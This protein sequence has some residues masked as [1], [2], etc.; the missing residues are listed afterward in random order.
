MLLHRP[1]RL[2]RSRAS[3]VKRDEARAIFLLAA[4]V[5]FCTLAAHTMI[6]P[7]SARFLKHVYNASSALGVALGVLLS[8][9][10]P[11][12]LET[13][14]V[15]ST[16]DGELDHRGRRVK[17]ERGAVYVLCEAC[18]RWRPPRAHHCRTCGRCV[19][20]LDHHCHGLRACIGQGTHG[21]FLLY[22]SLQAVATGTLARAGW[23]A[24]DEH[25]GFALGLA[26][27]GFGLCGAAGSLTLLAFTVMALAN[28]T[29]K[30]L[31]ERA[32]DTP[33]P[34]T[35]MLEMAARPLQRALARVFGP[36]VRR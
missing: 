6:F 26:A 21:L 30:E 1:F 2:A 20:D 17:R 27:T 34:A 13:T 11:V 15:A 4:T 14:A 9:M 35:G 25:G 18:A 7:R 31:E 22:L 10:E 36:R 3:R 33:R 8:S 23:Q 29:N 19:R 16:C 28:V 12:G 24:F 5:F 32:K